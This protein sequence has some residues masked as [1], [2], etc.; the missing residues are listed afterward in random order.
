MAHS[1]THTCF[2]TYQYSCQLQTHTLPPTTI[3]HTHV[4][5]HARTHTHSSRPNALHTIST[6]LL[7]RV[8][9]AQGVFE[10]AQ[11]CVCMQLCV[12]WLCDTNSTPLSVI[13][14][15]THCTVEAHMNQGGIVCSWSYSVLCQTE[16]SVK[17]VPA[18]VPWG[19]TLSIVSSSSASHPLAL[20]VFPS[21]A[22][23]FPSLCLAKLIR[24][25][26]MVW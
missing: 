13:I 1:H 18:P 16:G 25:W 21:L 24:V 10:F 23:L 22:S 14:T 7:S 26:L 5:I 6:L 4:H 20:S 8:K 15:Y 9:S 11:R 19:E 17:S 3:V 12:C 2:F